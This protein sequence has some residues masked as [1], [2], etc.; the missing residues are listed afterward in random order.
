MTSE[1]YVAEPASVTKARRFVAGMLDQASDE[2]RE[3]AVLI[4][5]E[6]AS[7]AVS[8]GEGAFTVTARLSADELYVAVTDGGLAVPVPRTPAPTEPHGRGLMIVASLADRWGVER[9]AVGK[10]VWFAL[11]LSTRRQRTP[12][13]EV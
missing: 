1:V 11:S 2:L 5:S 3:C 8:H 12:T 6:L 10:T 13:A 9:R 4:T 7:N